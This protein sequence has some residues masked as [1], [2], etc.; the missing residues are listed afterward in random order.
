MCLR[1][2]TGHG[3]AAGLVW[4]GPQQAVGTVPA[5]RQEVDGHPH[6]QAR[7][8]TGPGLG[9]GH[10]MLSACHTGIPTEAKMN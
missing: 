4:C 9:E 3:G 6:L 8:A 2:I 5:T 10:A 7:C 1:V